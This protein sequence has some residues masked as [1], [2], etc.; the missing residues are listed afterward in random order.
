MCKIED[1]VSKI[2][3]VKNS[4]SKLRR[5]NSNFIKRSLREYNNESINNN[6]VNDIFLFNSIE[7]INDFNNVEHLMFSI[8]ISLTN[9]F[10][11]LNQIRE[12]HQNLLNTINNGRQ[13][14][15]N[16]L[17]SLNN[18]LS[19]N[20]LINRIDTRFTN[21]IKKNNNRQLQVNQQV[22]NAV[23][24]ID[25][26]NNNFLN[27]AAAVGF[28]FIVGGIY[29]FFNSETISNNTILME[30]ITISLPG[31]KINTKPFN[32]IEGSIFLGL[33]KKL[34]FKK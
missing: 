3:N 27:I 15:Q 10:N 14:Y 1:R 34:F 21:I 19:F 31:L 20:T 8:N 12:I 28:T 9:Q 33:L 18:G 30:Q 25:I 2:L 24:N 26:S 6:E 13:F 11:S 23:N 4:T 16:G 29:I 22:L 5:K 17:L 32:L 7:S